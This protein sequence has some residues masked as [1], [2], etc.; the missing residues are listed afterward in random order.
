MGTALQ[1]SSLMGGSGISARCWVPVLLL[2]GGLVSVHWAQEPSRSPPPAKAGHER[3][4]VKQ[5]VTQHCTKC[6]NSDDKK[7]GLALDTIS[8]EDVN[9]H[10]QVWEKVVRKLAARQMPPVGR[11][12]PDERTYESIVAALEAELD[13]AAAARPHPGRTPT[14]RRL[15]RTEYQNAIRDLLAVDVD[16]TALLPPDEAN[17]GFDIAPL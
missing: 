7:G 5:F 17:H 16:A 1:E 2:A 9:A 11:S 6:H 3:P 14:L 12:R 13:R 15:N 8:S 10:P 4:T